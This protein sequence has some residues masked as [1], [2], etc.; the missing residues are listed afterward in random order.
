MIDEID[1]EDFE[2]TL[3]T[4]MDATCN[5]ELVS[6]VHKDNIL[7]GTWRWKANSH[8]DMMFSFKREEL[9]PEDIDHILHEIKTTIILGIC[10]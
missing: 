1:F 9:D 7:T 6:L 4:L 10:L 5:S 8:K 3:K 2:Y